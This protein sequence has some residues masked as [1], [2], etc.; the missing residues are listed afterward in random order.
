MYNERKY[1]GHKNIQ[2]IMTG[3]G[4]IARELRFLIGMSLVS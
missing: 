3:A 2:M 4:C 1:F